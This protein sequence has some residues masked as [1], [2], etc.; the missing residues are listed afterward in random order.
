[1]IKLLLILALLAAERGPWLLIGRIPDRN[2]YTCSES[3]SGTYVG[4]TASITD[5]SC[6]VWNLGGGV[7]PNIEILRNG[8]NSDGGF[9]TVILYYLG[10]VYV[11]GGDDNWYVWN[12]GYAFYSST[13]PS[14][15]VT[16]VG[17]FVSTTGSD[18]NSCIQAQTST[19]PKRNFSGASGALACLSAGSTLYARGGTYAESITS[20][21][22]GTSWSNKVRVT[23]YP[24]ETV[25]MV[26]TVANAGSNVIWL[27]ANVSYVEFD[28]I[29][30]DGRTSVQAGVWVST[31]NSRNPHHIRIQNAEII[32]G[33]VGSGGVILFGAHTVIGSV[34]GNEAINLTIHGGGIAGGCG[35]ACAEYG[36]YLAGPNNL[37]DGCNIYDV[38]GFG[39]Q[40]YNGGG[41]AATGN[42]VRNTLIHDITRYGDVDQVGGITIYGTGVNSIYN[43]VIYG[44][45][46]GTATG[47]TGNAAISVN[48]G[49]VGVKVMNNTIYEN[50]ANGIYLGTFPV[51][52]TGDIVQ[53]NI[54][55]L[56]GLN[57]F[58]QNGTGHTISNNLIGVNPIFV[59]PASFNFRLQS[60]STARDTGTALPSVFT[61]DLEAIPRP[62]G[63]LWDIGAYEYH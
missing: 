19:T 22:T 42:I 2:P 56:S 24:S 29:N 15:M 41:D 52:T 50:V 46:T 1:M 14:M 34:G 61:T 57:N 8:S 18:S 10:A 7:S 31:N 16:P 26:P 47:G 36:V 59:A 60:S 20:V 48:G 35:F 9:G 44:I 13:D 12:D 53:N 30:L 6:V 5:S 62:Q 28:G 39:I 27:D 11:K 63:P 23:N 55:Y 17:Y 3:S 58:V 49:S 51:A 45:A 43:N 37:V 54:V 25:W 21:P 33:A 38:S 32:G 4:P 40:I